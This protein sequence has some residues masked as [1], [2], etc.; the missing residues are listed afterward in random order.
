MIV[1]RAEDRAV[2]VA[3]D[4]ITKQK[5]IEDGLKTREEELQRKNNELKSLNVKL[6][7]SYNRIKQINS[8]FQHAKEKAEESERL[9]TAFLANMSHEIRTPLNGIV[10][11]TELLNDTKLDN[12][13]RRLYI[14]TV[15]NCSQQLIHI[16]NDILDISMIE[17]GQVFIRKKTVNLNQLLQDV[18]D[19]FWPSAERKQLK[20]SLSVPSG[21]K[22]F[23][24]HTDDEK[25]LQILNNLVNNALKFTHKGIVEFGYQLGDQKIIFCV[26]DTGIGIPPYMQGSIFERFVQSD[27]SDTREYG[28]N[29]L[30]LSIAKSYVELLHGTIWLESEINEGSVFYFTIPVSAAD[31]K[32]KSI[33]REVAVPDVPDLSGRTILIVEDDDTNFL[34]L[35]EVLRNHNATVIRASDGQDAIFKCRHHAEIDLVFLDLKLPILDGFKAAPIIKDLRKDL[36]VIAQSA[37]AFADEKQRALDAGCEAFIPKPIDFTKIASVLHEYIK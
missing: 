31:S 33:S 18:Y 5:K 4:D 13:K 37:F 2:L 19:Q 17:T 32:N 16:V 30:G 34:L 7:D 14:H 29:G 23:T 12:D 9:K 11:F 1:K 27:L 26:K 21:S 25:L 8:E 24:L 6:L 22:E 35:E 15:N 20:L 36:P 3:I 28:G 10:G